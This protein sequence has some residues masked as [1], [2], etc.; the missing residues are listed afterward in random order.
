MNLVE[1]IRGDAL[2]HF[3]ARNYRT[4]SPYLPLYILLIL[5]FCPGFQLALSMRVQSALGKLPVIGKPMRMILWYCSTICFGSDLDPAATF[6]PGIYFPHP[7]GIV[8]GGE[9]D[10]GSQVTIL[11]GVTLGRNGTPKGRCRVGDF[12]Q[13]GA[14]A[15]VIGNIDIGRS[16]SIGANSVVLKSVPDNALAVGVPA[17]IITK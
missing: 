1:N 11:H 4:R 16:S 9:W 2:R 15:K 13:I 7:I 8:I 3:K 12:S 17:R 6:G 5:L 10:I 14:G